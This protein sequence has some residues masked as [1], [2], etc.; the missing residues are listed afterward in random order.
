MVAMQSNSDFEEIL[1]AF[2]VAGVKYLVVGAYAVAAHSR[3]R[4]TGD[5]DLWVEASADN[6]RRVFRALAA[7]GAPMEH[8]DEQTFREADIVLQIG[9]P[10]IRI[11]VLTGIDG[12]S[13]DEAWPNRVPSTVGKAP[14]HVLG[15]VDL[16]RNKKAS[17]RAKDL[18][19]LER[20]ERDG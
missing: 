2:N 19:D 9:V 13:F 3:P 14:T 11:D 7:F 20:L 10:P 18:A 8:V 6:S 1:L 12:I 4:A 15:R 16:I 17:G 5:I